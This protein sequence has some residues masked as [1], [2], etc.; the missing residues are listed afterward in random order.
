MELQYYY[1]KLAYVYFGINQMSNNIDVAEKEE[2]LIE[3]RNK[4]KTEEIMQ[5]FCNSDYKL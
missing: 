2:F 5:K 3:R 4:Y 1:M